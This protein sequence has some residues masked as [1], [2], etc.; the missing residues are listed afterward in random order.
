[1]GREQWRRASKNLSPFCRDPAVFCG[2]TI[3][4]QTVLSTVHFSQ[5]LASWRQIFPLTYRGYF[6]FQCQALTMGS[7]TYWVY[8]GQ[9]PNTAQQLLKWKMTTLHSKQWAHYLPF[10]VSICIFWRVPFFLSEA[11][12]SLPFLWGNVEELVDGNCLTKKILQYFF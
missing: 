2:M 3:G 8:T 6:S 11:A 10:S 4:F 9:H 7:Y 12:F 1:M 5:V